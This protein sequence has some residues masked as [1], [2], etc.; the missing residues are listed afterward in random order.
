MQSLEI[1]FGAAPRSTRWWLGAS[2]VLLLSVG[3][4]GWRAQLLAQRDVLLSALTVETASP[5]PSHA[6][7]NAAARK[8]EDEI[9]AMAAA[10]RY[11]W[12]AVWGALQ[13][14][15]GSIKTL[16]LEPVSVRDGTWRLTGQAQDSASMLD[17][18]Q[19]LSVEPAWR[20]V[21]LESETF[22]EAA[23][24]VGTSSVVFQVALEWADH[25]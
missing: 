6:S 11:P 9:R 22:Q 15:E 21:H 16:Y 2:L 12:G 18:L 17:F 13:R 20:S 1:D 3:L 4:V 14:V 19:R 25:E 8:S 23:T 24:N 5:R 7:T 10:L